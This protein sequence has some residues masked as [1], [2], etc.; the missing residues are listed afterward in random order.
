[1]Q[2]QGL[3]TTVLGSAD[4]D[5]NDCEMGVTALVEAV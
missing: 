1:M 5:A 3:E 2:L 4:E